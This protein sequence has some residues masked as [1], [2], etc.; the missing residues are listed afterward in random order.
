[1]NCEL[2]KIINS[3]IE[4]GRY[5]TLCII[6]EES[7]STP[8]SRGASMWVRLDGTISGTIGGGIA[9]FEAI[10]EAIALMKSDQNSMMWHK[11]LTGHE[12]MVCGGKI[13]VFMEVIGRD[14]EL[15]IFGAGHTGKALAELGVY[16]GFN[17]TIWDER[18]DF[19]KGVSNPSIKKVSCP[20]EKIFENGMSFH[21]RSYVVIMTRGHE[22]DSEVVTALQEKD[23]AYFGM[24]G[25]RTKIAAVR[26][27]LLEAGVPAAHLDRIHQPVG[28]PI[29]AETP[30]EIAVSIMAEIIAVKRNA[31]LDSLRCAL[32]N[33]K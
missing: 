14:E 10:Q 12:G 15:V 4:Q 19:L 22:L 11:S 26:K 32:K 1:M 3:E 8:R 21:D 6:T 16:A 25:S 27:N 28:L 2:L 20:V 9:E 24:I 33:P 5:G 18:D 31:D 30:E 23:C 13:S 17:V 7:G 29:R